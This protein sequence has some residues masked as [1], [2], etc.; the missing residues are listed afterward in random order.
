MVFSMLENGWEDAEIC[1]ELG[2]EPEEL[3]R[4]KHITGFSKLFADVEY[5]KSWTTKKQILIEKKWRDAHPE[6]QSVS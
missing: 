6:D 1:G 3:V 5:R 4:L 2:M